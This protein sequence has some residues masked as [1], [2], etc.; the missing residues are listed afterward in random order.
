MALIV[1]SVPLL[2]RLL[3]S[4]YS[5]VTEGSS[6]EHWSKTNLRHSLRTQKEKRGSSWH[7]TWEGVNELE[8]QKENYGINQ[9]S[10]V[11]LPH[12]SVIYCEISLQ[13]LSS[14]SPFPSPNPL[15]CIVTISNSKG[16]T[17]NIL[18]CQGLWNRWH[19]F[20]SSWLCQTE[21]MQTPHASLF[22]LGLL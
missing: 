14:P 10:Q 2:V 20:I 18:P 6:V 17:F 16:L 15:S 12:S 13:L 8:E 4:E 1:S 5:L 11:L 19:I 9:S 3:S 21:C 22:D 7:D